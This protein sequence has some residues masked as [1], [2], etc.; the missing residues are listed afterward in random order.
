LQ[1][2][3]PISGHGC[4]I[5]NIKAFQSQD[6]AKLILKISRMLAGEDFGNGMLIKQRTCGVRLLRVA[7]WH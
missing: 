7:D 1:A 2:A 5:I 6:V 3:F 4:G